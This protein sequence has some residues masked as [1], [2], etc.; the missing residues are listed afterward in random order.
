MVNKLIDLK[1][2]TELFVI[3]QLIWFFNMFHLS[4][5]ERSRYIA[6]VLL[7]QD[8]NDIN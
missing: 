4:I 2:Y 6:S 1:I 7:Y 3:C 5:L 8:D